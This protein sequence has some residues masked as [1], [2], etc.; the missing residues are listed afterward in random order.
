MQTTY[1]IRLDIGS[2][3]QNRRLF[4]RL[5]TPN[6][7][8]GT[9]ITVREVQRGADGQHL[10]YSVSEGIGALFCGYTA[11]GSNDERSMRWYDPVPLPATTEPTPV[12]STPF[13]RLYWA[14]QESLPVK[15]G[16]DTP[17][18]QECQSGSCSKSSEAAPQQDAP[19]EVVEDDT[20]AEQPADAPEASHE[21]SAVEDDAEAVEDAQEPCEHPC[22]HEDEADCDESC[23][24]EDDEEEIA[25]LT[26]E[27]FSSL[28]AKQKRAYIAE[29][30]QSPYI[31]ERSN[32]AMIAG[33]TKYLASFESLDD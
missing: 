13:G 15:E 31:D 10:A 14:G 25:L 30:G 4:I 21:P 11:D 7:Q 16:C 28:T 2:Q 33:Y 9:D 17:C 1:R 29:I 6:S 23:E 8:G 24:G 12:R 5:A 3:P 20:P 27:A 26:V 22:E 32:K 18:K 19:V